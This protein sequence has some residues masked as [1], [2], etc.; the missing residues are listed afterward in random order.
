MLLVNNPGRWGNVYI[1]PPLR[2]AAWNGWTPTDLIFPNFL[3]IVG[4]ALV[5]SFS[6]RLD[7][8]HS[9]T[10]LWLHVVR[11]AAVLIL[12]GLFQS[13]F[14]F[15]PQDTTGLGQAMAEAGSGGALLRVGLLLGFTAGVVLILGARSTRTWLIVLASGVICGVLGQILAS[16]VDSRWFWQHLATAR[17]PGVLFRIGICYLLAG[18]IYL[19]WRRPRTLVA[20]TS[21]LV[22][23]SA[24]WMLWVPIPGYGC[25]D[26]DLGL[27]QAD[28]EPT[29][30]MSNWGA[31]ID[32]RIFGVRCL[33]TALD[34]GTGGLA[35]AFDPEGLASTPAALATVMMGILCGIWIHGDSGNRL[36]SEKRRVAGGLVAMA[37]LAIASGAAFG[38]GLPLN[39]QL[40]TSSYAVFTAGMALLMLAACYAML[41]IASWRRWATP[42]IWYGRNAILA[43]FLSSLLARLLVHLK[44]A[45]TS[46]SGVVEHLTLKTRIF[47]SLFLSWAAPRPASLLYALAVVLL[48]GAVC[49]LLYRKRIFIKI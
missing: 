42:F 34:P 21:L 38:F 36:P 44:V 29:R 27:W 39:K 45:T 48:W 37:M 40:W 6:R 28:G 23:V 22:V 5:F 49:G 35:W 8:G 47:E 11:R 14:P 33:Y 17:V 4:V 2:H 9:R 46:A 3:F 13:R 24:V 18:S 1:Y 12:L 26:L 20:V 15:Y 30:L 25:P 7:E 10:T 41:D 16:P 31:F 43:F 32:T 19:R